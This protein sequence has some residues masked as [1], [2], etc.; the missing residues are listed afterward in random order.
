[1][2]TP[3][4]QPPHH[5]R[6]HAAPAGALRAR[7]AAARRRVDPRPRDDLSLSR[8]ADA[9]GGRGA[10][11]GGVGTPRRAEARQR[12]PARHLRRRLRDHR[13]RPRRGHAPLAPARADADRRGRRRSARASPASISSRRAPRSTAPKASTSTAELRDRASLESA[14]AGAAVVPVGRGRVAALPRR[15]GRGARR[16]RDRSPTTRRSR[17]DSKRIG[18][19]REGRAIP[20]RDRA[21]IAA[22]HRRHQAAR[23]LHACAAHDLPPIGADVR[24]GGHLVDRV[25]SVVRLT[26]RR[27]HR[28]DRA[29][30]LDRCRRHA[31]PDRGRRPELDGRGGAPS[32]RVSR[33]GAAGRARHD[34]ARGH[35]H[36][37]RCGVAW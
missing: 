37:L 31:A 18:G 4:L 13:A 12:A 3:W 23:R 2:R 16:P 15:M 35:P 1:M 19:R 32:V 10:A 22:S 11:R 29:A 6:H 27:H 8:S 14:L 20:G 34:H 24:V 26:A 9:A 21:R 5:R 7:A 17:P 25:R 30:H 36:H 33:H 28:D